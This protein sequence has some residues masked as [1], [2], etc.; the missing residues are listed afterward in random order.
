MFSVNKTNIQSTNT[1]CIAI[2]KAKCFSYT[3][4]HHQLYRRK[5]KVLTHTSDTYGVDYLLV[6]LTE[7]IREMYCLKIKNA[8]AAY[9]QLKNKERNLYNCKANVYFI[10]YEISQLY[11]KHFLFLLYSP[12]TAI[13]TART[14]SC[15]Y[16]SKYMLS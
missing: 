7:N 1:T 14:C 13:S 3:N 4:C 16:V 2:S 15:W 5:H 8:S 6:L 9:I 11:V 12:V 10:P